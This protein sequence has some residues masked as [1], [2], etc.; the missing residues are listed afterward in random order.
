MKTAI[1]TSQDNWH[2]GW[3]LKQEDLDIALA[4][5]RKGGLEVTVYNVTSVPDLM[6]TLDS[7][8]PDTLIWANAYY[9]NSTDGKVAWLNDL[10]AERDLP[11]LGS[12]TQTLKEIL[13]KDVC[14]SV[15]QQQGIPV[16][17]FISLDRTAIRELP[18]RLNATDMTFP[19]V[20]KPTNEG[21]SM[22]VKLVHSL[23]ELMSHTNY[24]ATELPGS[25]IMVESFLPNDDMTTGWLQ[26]GDE[27]LLMPSRYVIKNAPGSESVLSRE[28][29]FRPWDEQ[30]KMQYFI[31][32]SA[33]LEQI[34]Q[35]V[36]KIAGL[37]RIQDVTRMDGRLDAQG[38]FRFY[39]IN[40]FPG[41]RYAKSV[42]TRQCA[43]FFPQYND[44]EIYHGLL[45]TFVHNA[46]T[47]NGLEV[48]QAMQNF[49]LFTMESERAIRISKEVV[50]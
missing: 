5:L 23:S 19:L 6:R 4:S 27:I 32:D 9:V 40:G 22:G 13:D 42:I 44:E 14:Q 46:L 15:L 10:I 43:L 17:D 18:D 1:I 16:P 3:F 31:E 7:I 36:P 11:M 21:G 26:L 29:Q 45:N 8:P 50:L 35:H 34:K 48:P 47:R 37:F 28:N 25:N 41:M 39:D 2:K 12:S 33:T 30:N 49:N 38:V 24:I 20:V